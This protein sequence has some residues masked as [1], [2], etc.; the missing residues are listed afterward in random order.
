MFD[1][2]WITILF[3]FVFIAAFY[4]TAKMKGRIDQLSEDMD[5]IA[6]YRRADN[7]LYGIPDGRYV[8]VT[9]STI[10]VNDG[11]VISVYKHKSISQ[12]H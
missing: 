1:I 6:K 9:G 11:R 12:A 10:T 7:L 2:L 4:R 5:N 8:H 3:G